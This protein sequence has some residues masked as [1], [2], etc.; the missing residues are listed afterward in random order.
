MNGEK[1]DLWL[2]GNEVYKSLV[3]SLFQANGEKDDSTITFHVGIYKVSSE[4][5]K[6]NHKK[7]QEL[8]LNDSLIY[9]LSIYW[10]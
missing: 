5:I 3:L 4:F 6:S 7:E 8:G 2:Y 10:Y 9:I 1:D